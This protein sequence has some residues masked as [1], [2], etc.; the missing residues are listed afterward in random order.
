VKYMIQHL[1]IKHRPTYDPGN[2][3]DGELFDV[4]AAVDPEA[5][6]K[7]GRGIARLG[8]FKSSMVIPS[9]I[10]VI[11]TTG[12][13]PFLTNS[14]MP[15]EELSQNAQNKSV[16]RAS[17]EGLPGILF[18]ANLNASL[19]TCSW[20]SP[21]NSKMTLLTAIREAQWSKDPFP[22]PIRTYLS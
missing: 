5:R 7:S 8:L 6:G 15:I 4:T 14:Y 20:T 13:S 17:R 11:P 16:S 18:P 12:G 10:L 9:T 1:Q 2:T 19:A 3:D 21:F 22:L